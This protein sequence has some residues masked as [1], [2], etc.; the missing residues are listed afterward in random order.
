MN[1][2]KLI[3]RGIKGQLWSRDKV[4]FKNDLILKPLSCLFIAQAMHMKLSL[5]RSSHRGSVE[6]NPTSIHD[7]M[8]SIPG[9]T[10]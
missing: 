7:V 6:M 9:L 10:Q 5:L 4:I 3:R 1:K 2:K 8:G